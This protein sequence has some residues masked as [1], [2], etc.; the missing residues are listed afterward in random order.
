MSTLRGVDKGQ[1]L[2]GAMLAATLQLSPVTIKAE[3]EAL[4]K[5]TPEIRVVADSQAHEFYGAPTFLQSAVADRVSDV[6]IRTSQQRLFGESM[7]VAAL[8]EARR[9]GEIDTVLHL[10]DAM[11]VSCTS[12]W[13]SF[14]AAMARSERAW[15]LIP[16]NHDG[17]FLGN[18][19]PAL[20]AQSTWNLASDSYGSAGWKLRC[21]AR[22]V[23][24][25]ERPLDRTGFLDLALD[26]LRQLPGAAVSICERPNCFSVSWESDVKAVAVL[27]IDR[28]RPWRSFMAQRIVVPASACGRSPDS[29]SDLTI[30]GIDTS[31][32]ARQPRFV[33]W[34]K[35]AGIRAGI[36][37]ETQGQL[38][39]SWVNDT[40]GPVIVAGHHSLLDFQAGHR[41]H[42]LSILCSSATPIYVS[43]HTHVGYWQRWNCPSNEKQVVELNVSS[44]IDA[45][46]SYRT[47]Q[48]LVDADGQTV[49]R[50]RF[51]RIGTYCAALQGEFG[52]SELAPERTARGQRDALNLSREIRRVPVAQGRNAQ[53][54]GIEGEL[55]EFRELLVRFP[56]LEPEN[57]HDELFLK[58]IGRSLK[59]L[60]KTRGTAS[61]DRVH[62]QELLVQLRLHEG[63]RPVADHAKREK[64]KVCLGINAAEQDARP[65]RLQSGQWPRETEIMRLNER[66]PR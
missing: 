6:A 7:L 3:D 46:A 34:Q 51:S 60:S 41:Q 61:G 33:D 1:S 28:E 58:R 13:R 62:H 4:I 36:D 10:G 24:L 22:N 54:R 57:A 18:L 31:Q 32:Y 5:V 19:H 23:L 43:A 49:I 16:G 52:V 11:D 64:Y 27:S 59:Q 30:V 66:L 53:L 38:V 35:P 21:S 55:R 14:G 9:P 50:S 20:D 56:S 2:F 8:T 48:L 12:E 42:L 63:S 39:S 15:V 47:I 65:T 45:P 26:R 37:L 29:C 40:S 25:N 17:Y 44:V